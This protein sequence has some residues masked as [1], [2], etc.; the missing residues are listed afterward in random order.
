[1]SYCLH[2]SRYQGVFG[3]EGLTSDENVGGLPVDVPQDRVDAV[4]GVRD[5]R[6]LVW[7]SAD[8]LGDHRP[9]LRHHSRQLKAHEQVGIS[10][11][12]S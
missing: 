4:G 1:M 3:S 5:K 2:E 12:V 8:E 11:D 10:L 7:L 6:H 9:R